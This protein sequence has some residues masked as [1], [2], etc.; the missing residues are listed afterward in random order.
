M[1]LLSCFVACQSTFW[2]VVAHC[3]SGKCSSSASLRFF[4]CTGDVR[5]SARSVTRLSTLT[6]SDGSGD[7]CPR[8]REQKTLTGTS[9]DLKEWT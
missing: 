3:C 2:F 9:N 5:H 7:A 6:S 1:L 8:V 4:F